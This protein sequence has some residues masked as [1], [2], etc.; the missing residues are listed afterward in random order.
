ME[1][2]KLVVT[3]ADNLTEA[4]FETPGETPGEVEE[5]SMVDTEVEA[6]SKTLYDILGSKHWDFWQHTLGD[7]D[8]EAQILT[9]E[10]HFFRRK[11]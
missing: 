1:A 11:D 4:E 5:K 9:L 10:L 6:K 7:V 2:K 3:L 8:A